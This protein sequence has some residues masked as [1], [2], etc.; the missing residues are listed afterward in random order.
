[1]LP[2]QGLELADDGGVPAELELRLDPRL[3]RLHA[4]FAQPLDIRPRPRLRAELAEHGP[5]PQRQRLSQRRRREL[6]LAVDE[7]TV[8]P[9][10]ELTES[11]RVACARGNRQGVAVPARRDCAVAERA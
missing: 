2:A 11:V 6:S 7:C 4:L 1:M 10:D 9:G 3:E 5:A 8:A